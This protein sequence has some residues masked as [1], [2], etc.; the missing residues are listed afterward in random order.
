MLLP[1]AGWLENGPCACGA[2][3]NSCRRWRNVRVRWERHGGSV[4][5]HIVW[6]NRYLRMRRFWRL[7]QNIRRPTADFQTYV[8]KTRLLYR[9]ISEEFGTNI[10]VDSS[11]WPLHA[12]FLSNVPRID[13]RIIHLVRDPRGVAWSRQKT[14]GQAESKPRPSH[15]QS[16]WYSAFAWNLVNFSVSR[17]RRRVHPSDSARIR[18]EDLCLQ[19]RSTLERI[20][21]VADV[22]VDPVVAR[23]ENE[24]GL[25]VGHT[26][27]GNRLRLQKHVRL[28]TPDRAWRQGLSS[29]ENLAISIICGPSMYL[30]GY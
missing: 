11:K 20:G 10:L 16:I 5:E 4:T 26:V 18:Y 29:L 6:Q 15:A 24:E 30:Y 12:L 21:T 25:P 19:P 13:V 8:A 7:V 2:R 9:C 23:V 14:F 3:C 28:Q 27:A 1:R 22:R 17:V